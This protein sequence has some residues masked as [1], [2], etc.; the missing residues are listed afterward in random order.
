MLALLPA[1]IVAA[2]FQTDDLGSLSG[3]VVNSATG[4]PVHKTQVIAEPEGSGKG[5]TRATMTDSSGRFGFANVEAGRYRLRARR[6]GFLETHFGARRAESKGAVLTLGP[7]QEVKDLIIKLRPFGVITG[8]VRD[9]DGDPLEGAAVS[10]LRFQYEKGKREIMVAGRAWTDDIGQYRIANLIPGPYYVRAKP[11]PPESDITAAGDSESRAGML[12]LAPVLYPGVAEGRA[13]TPIEVG[14]RVPAA[15]IDL[16]LPLIK[17]FRV[18][19]QVALPAGNTTAANVRLLPMPA[20]EPE[21]IFLDL[22]A[23]VD[24]DGRFEIRQVPAGLYRLQAAASQRDGGAFGLITGYAEVMVSREDVDGV[25]VALER[26]AEVRVR[27]AVEGEDA[28]RL[29]GANIGVAGLDSGPSFNRVL[30]P[31][32]AGFRLELPRGRYSVAVEPPV[33][34]RLLIVKRVRAAA[35]DVLGEGLTIAGPGEFEV[36]IVLSEDAGSVTGMVAGEDG[37]PIQ[38]ATVVVVP[39]D[40]RARL[41]LFKETTTD[42]NG[43]FELSPVAPG[44]YKVFAWD[45][46]EPGIW[47]DGEFLKRFE[48]KAESLKVVA[49][50][51]ASLT[52][53]AIGET[54]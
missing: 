21:M 11:A 26:S 10:A 44:D 40:L 51:Q 12:T 37:K 6:N 32:E 41:D 24:K 39:A 28:P 3:A 1:V 4:E 33:K 22:S 49:K 31:G 5:G 48:A 29:E 19:G 35:T 8:T 47:F 53:R 43:R 27:L 20:V 38:G 50:G 23:E 13:A 9:S 15:G 46:V 18:R 7:G 36:D 2:A 16:T 52:L 25:R 30:R 14:A 17:V 42:Q 34:R 45:E 54:R